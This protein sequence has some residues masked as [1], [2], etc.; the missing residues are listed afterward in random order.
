MSKPISERS[1]GLSDSL[2]PI[3]RF[4]HESSW[5]RR[6]GES[7]ICDFSMGNPHEMPLRDLVT[8][9]SRWIEPRNESWYA[10]KMNETA[11]REVL[12]G[13]LRKWRNMPFEAE[14]IFV[15]NGAIAALAVVLVS[16]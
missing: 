7:G 5:S 3:F 14:D 10:Y 4:L 13:S 16:V 9:Y 15:T 1:A 6:R 2:S 8:A 12:A 11:S